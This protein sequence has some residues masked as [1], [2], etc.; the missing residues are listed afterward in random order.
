MASHPNQPQTKEIFFDSD[1][2]L[3]KHIG[4]N[5]IDSETIALIE[6]FMANTCS[7][8]QF[9]PHKVAGGRRGGLQPQGNL[10]QVRGD[11]R[12]PQ[13][14]SQNHQQLYLLPLCR[15]HARRCR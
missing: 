8:K 12:S 10:R 9:L 11:F 6:T 7:D 5:Q 15:Q 4:R 13:Q 1:G 14:Q 3:F 2:K